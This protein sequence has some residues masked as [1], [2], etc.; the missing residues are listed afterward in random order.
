MSHLAASSVYS[1]LYVKACHPLDVHRP[2]LFWSSVTSSLPSPTTT[3]P[4]QPPLSGSKNVFLS[5]QFGVE[6][7]L[8]SLRVLPPFLSSARIDEDGSPASAD[9]HF[10]STLKP[11]RSQTTRTTRMI[12]LLHN[13]SHAFDVIKNV[14]LATQELGT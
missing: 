7:P 2:V 12:C 8:F 11:D 6:I 3:I 9:P 10:R 13:K 14:H 4:R 5:R 1:P